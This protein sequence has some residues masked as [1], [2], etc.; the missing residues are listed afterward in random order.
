MAQIFEEMADI[1]S[2]KKAGAF[3]KAKDKLKESVDKIMSARGNTI[4]SIMGGLDLHYE[5]V[6][7]QLEGEDRNI[8]DRLKGLTHPS[9][10]AIERFKAMGGDL[11]QARA[12]D[13]LIRSFDLHLSKF[14]SIKGEHNSLNAEYQD[15]LKGLRGF[16]K[17]SSALHM[18]T[19]ANEDVKKSEVPEPSVIKDSN[20]DLLSAFAYMGMDITKKADGTFEVKEVPNGGLPYKDASG[21]VQYARISREATTSFINNYIRTGGVSYEKEERELAEAEEILDNM[22]GNLKAGGMYAP[23]ESDIAKQQKKIESIKSAIETKK[24]QTITPKG[25]FT[26]FVEKELIGNTSKRRLDKEVLLRAQ[27]QFSVD[28]PEWEAYNMSRNPDLFLDDLRIA[29]VAKA[30]VTELERGGFINL[31]KIPDYA[32]MLTSDASNTLMNRRRAGKI[33]AYHESV[34]DRAQDLADA[35][36][37][38]SQAISDKYQGML[39]SLQERANLYTQSR[40][41]IPASLSKSIAELQKKNE[42]LTQYQALH[43]LVNESLKENKTVQIRCPH[44]LNGELNSKR[45]YEELAKHISFENGELILNDDLVDSKG[46]AWLT[47]E[48]FSKFMSGE[49]EKTAEQEEPEEEAENETPQNEPNTSSNGAQHEAKVD[50]LPDVGPYSLGVALP[51]NMTFESAMEAYAMQDRAIT[52]LEEG[53]NFIAD[54]Y[55]GFKKSGK[56]AEEF[57]GA[58]EAQSGTNGL[59]SLAGVCDINT[60]KNVFDY[61]REKEAGSSK[62]PPTEVSIRDTAGTSAIYDNARRAYYYMDIVSNNIFTDPK[63]RET[64]EKG[65]EDERKQLFET[66]FEN[67]KANGLLNTAPSEEQLK[68]AEA[69]WGHYYNI[70]STE[71]LANEM[72]GDVDNPNCQKIL[73][74][75]AK[76]ASKNEKLLETETARLEAEGKPVVEYAME[77]EKQNEEKPKKLIQFKELYPR[78]TPQ[79]KISKE[80][81]PYNIKAGLKF[82]DQIMD[83]FNKV[84]VEDPWATANKVTD[85]DVENIVKSVQGNG[86]AKNTDA[87]KTDDGTQKN[88]EEAQKGEETTAPAQETPATPETP[89]TPET[90]ATPE[91]PQ[92]PQTPENP[93]T[94]E[95]KNA[96]AR[97]AEPKSTGN[98][99]FDGLSDDQVRARTAMMA[100]GMGIESILGKLDL[101]KENIDADQ[102]ITAVNYMNRANVELQPKVDLDGQTICTT[103]AMQKILLEYATGKPKEE[104][105]GRM[106]GITDQ[107]RSM[108][109]KNLEYLADNLN[110]IN[111]IMG[112]LTPAELVNMLSTTAKMSPAKEGEPM[113]IE[114]GSKLTPEDIAVFRQTKDINNVKDLIVQSGMYN[115]ATID[116]IFK[117]GKEMKNPE[118]G[119]EITR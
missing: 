112:L 56:S 107:I 50:M 115:Q 108:G 21:V 9:E 61:Y 70:G 5:S 118:A 95:P 16:D 69:R 98:I 74:V 10:S 93:E 100:V 24:A 17:M 90:P 80:L 1:S 86:N 18:A 82:L 25:L 110:S 73:S 106:N 77:K 13:D 2:V 28:S 48:D 41:A 59:G 67:L 103:D 84:L 37:N 116:E 31:R 29:S 65:T 57:I 34:V 32:G 8:F 79:F 35:N 44:V 33:E 46:E 26:Y 109:N 49:M 64:Y 30:N 114:L 75:L 111:T 6:G 39:T 101:G 38:A 104:C 62:T 99:H 14:K 88:D 72:S 12:Y 45:F 43:S 27:R 76:N 68:D 117:A 20:E 94:S 96:E 83:A 87:P 102:L 51:N 63:L 23:S 52:M 19:Y 71:K 105:V 91:T 78:G 15:W 4:E 58:I 66:T 85:K 60:L 11:A 47:K 81:Q 55:D 54:L 40:Q 3:V 89:Q 36:E 97:T 53:N 92:T 42:L 7:D 113:T 22:R 119:V